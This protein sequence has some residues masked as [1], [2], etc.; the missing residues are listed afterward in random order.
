MNRFDVTRFL[1]VDMKLLAGSRCE[2]ARQKAEINKKRLNS[3][4]LL[5]SPIQWFNGPGTKGNRR[6]QAVVYGKV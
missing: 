4:W 5:R 2:T 3:Q 6:L 1:A